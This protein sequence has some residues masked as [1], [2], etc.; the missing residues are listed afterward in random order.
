M[1]ILAPYFRKHLL[2]GFEPR[3]QTSRFQFLRFFLIPR[4]SF[5]LKSE[6][7]KNKIAGVD[8]TRQILFFFFFWGIFPP[9]WLEESTDG[10]LS[11]QACTSLKQLAGKD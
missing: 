10:E 2:L 5:R 1:I 8:G 11:L 9:I 6:K 3:T 7:N 4:G